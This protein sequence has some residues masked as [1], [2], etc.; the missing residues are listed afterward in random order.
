MPLSFHLVPNLQGKQSWLYH[1]TAY[2]MTR[3]FLLHSELMRMLLWSIPW[4]SL[5][6]SVSSSFLTL[7]QRSIY[8]I[9]IA[10]L[11]AV[12]TSQLHHFS[13]EL[14]LAFCL[15]IWL[16]CFQQIEHF[17]KW[18][19][20]WLFALSMLKKVMDFCVQ[21]VLE[22]IHPIPW[23]HQETASER[24]HLALASK[25]HVII[26][27]DKSWSMSEEGHSH[28]PAPSPTPSVVSCE[29]KPRMI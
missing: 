25:R 27:C 3:Y 11:Q 29:G 14:R 17:H 23:M 21:K 22:V 24:S 13:F 1:I 19:V 9:D 8:L 10:S 18:M 7:R 28:G 12:M 15:T 6:K 2:A 5:Y 16:E 20:F 4:L 26:F